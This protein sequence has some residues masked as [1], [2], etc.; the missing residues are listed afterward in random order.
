MTTLGE[1]DLTGD[2]EVDLEYGDDA[3]GLLGLT[4]T[5]PPEWWLR[6][7]LKSG[8]EM[9]GWRRGAGARLVAGL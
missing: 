2:V 9:L 5:P 4:M 8:R 6:A 3:P 7:L 1:G